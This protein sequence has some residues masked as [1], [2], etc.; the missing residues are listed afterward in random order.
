[1]MCIERSVKKSGFTIVELLTV[2]GII[3]VLI[4]LLVPAL[5]AV[6]DYADTI[7]QKAQFHSI[8]VG[9]DLYVAEYETYPESNNNS[10]APTHLYDATPY[11][12]AQKLAEAMVGLDFLGF[13]HNS[14][15][16]ADGQFIHPVDTTTDVY[17]A[18]SDYDPVN[19]AYTETAEA[20][21]QARNKFI[22]LENA[23][24]FMIE[25]VY[26][27]IDTFLF[28]PNFRVYPTLVLCDVY[29]M[30]RTSGKKAGTPILYFKANT[31][32]KFQDSTNGS[33]LDDVY[34]YDDNGLLLSVGSADS[35]AVAH[36]LADGV[37]D[38]L[39][40]DNILINQQVLE[41][42]GG[43]GV[44]AQVPYKSQSYILMSAG[45]DGLF[46]NSD[47]IYNFKKEE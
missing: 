37:D 31:L 13:H 21:V 26:N 1:M 38:L 44:G 42:S 15:F 34:N 18:G 25:D 10:V 5:S 16:R 32:F 3:A 14:D 30:K 41:A 24:A 17:H 8:E 11:T 43:T 23:N 28:K 4:G 40:F 36:P 27:D 22:D 39:D 35:S 12:G 45:K 46:G 7:Q 19:T 2:M 20:N 6:R 29:T 9:I 33:T 47:D